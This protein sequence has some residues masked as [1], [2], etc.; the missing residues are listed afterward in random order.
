MWF[1]KKKLKVRHVA[2]ENKVQKYKYLIQQFKNS[3]SQVSVWL[4]YF[5]STKNEMSH[6]CIATGTEVEIAT[7][8]QLLKKG[9]N[10][11]DARQIDL[12]QV[13][14]YDE[15][16][17]LETHPLLSIHNQFTAMAEKA[18]FKGLTCFTSL[19]APIMQL[20]GGERLKNIMS[21]LGLKEAEPIEHALVSK[22]IEKAMEKC[23]ENLKSHQD[24]RSSPEEWLTANPIKP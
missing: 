22:S 2:F 17:L 7:N 19:D 21:Q 3:S 24:I 11:M 9:I 1:S 8:N 23:E 15:L 18:N 12:A 6:L 20:F 16:L 10:L 13:H 4:Y 5:E 14:G